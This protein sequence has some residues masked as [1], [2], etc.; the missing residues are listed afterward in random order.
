MNK[1]LLHP[2]QDAYHSVKS[3]KEFL[4][5]AVDHITALD[6]GKLVSVASIDLWKAF[7]SFN[8]CLLIQRISELC[9]CSQY[10][11]GIVLRLSVKL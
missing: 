8:H 2:H 5:S 6:K 11:S 10:S 1:S 7:D 4:L 9:R 3:T